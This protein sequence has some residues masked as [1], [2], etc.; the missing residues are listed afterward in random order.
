M[1]KKLQLKLDDLEVTS[2]ETA[3]IASARGTVDGHAKPTVIVSCRCE[4]TDPAR[5][6]T[7]GCSINTDCPDTCVVMGIGPVIQ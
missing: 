5:D 2:F 6:C 3:P 4:P 7:L 1:R